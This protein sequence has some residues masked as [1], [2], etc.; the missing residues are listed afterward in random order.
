MRKNGQAQTMMRI[1]RYG[2]DRNKEHYITMFEF[3]VYAREIEIRFTPCSI[4]F[5]DYRM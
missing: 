2:R 4:S 5:H 3:E 1:G